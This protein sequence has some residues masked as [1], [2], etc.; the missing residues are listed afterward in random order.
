MN[1]Q[2]V[3]DR[4]PVNQPI[5]LYACRARSTD[6]DL[7]QATVSVTPSRASVRIEHSFS[8]RLF[9]TASAPYGLL[10]RK[11]PTVWFFFESRDE[12]LTWA[13]E[14]LEAGCRTRLSEN[15]RAGQRIALL[16]S[17]IAADDETF[18]QA[19]AAETRGFI[20]ELK[21]DGVAT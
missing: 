13:K 15:E 16:A 4:L 3:A 11:T 21:G 20:A 5:D 17:L 7:V 6:F 1:L 8:K 10:N 12:A 18:Q 9:G 14:R 19:V 2:Q